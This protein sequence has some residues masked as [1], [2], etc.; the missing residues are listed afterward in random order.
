MK[1]SKIMEELERIKDEYGDLTV[2]LGVYNMGGEMNSKDIH[3]IKVND[4]KVMLAVD[5]E[6]YKR[7][8]MKWNRLRN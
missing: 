2:V 1:V 3:F 7:A 5:P 6:E 8:S 4:D